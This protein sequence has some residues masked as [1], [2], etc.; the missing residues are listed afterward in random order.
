MLGS[1]LIEFHPSA[2]N[3]PGAPTPRRRAAVAFGLCVFSIVIRNNDSAPGYLDFR[4]YD[5][6]QDS[7]SGFSVIFLRLELARLHL[8]NYWG[9]SIVVGCVSAH[10]AEMA[11]A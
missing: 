1:S 9:W 11:H 8:T 4:S 3:P 5:T 2:V 10:P 7:R 6:G